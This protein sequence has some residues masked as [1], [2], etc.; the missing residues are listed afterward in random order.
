MINDGDDNI[1]ENKGL[2]EMDDVDYYFN[3]INEESD[4]SQEEKNNFNEK[5]YIISKIYSEVEHQATLHV[6]GFRSD[7]YNTSSFF[8]SSDHPYRGVNIGYK[9]NNNNNNSDGVI[10]VDDMDD[11]VDFMSDTD[12][13]GK[14][15]IGWGQV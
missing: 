8:R 1:D 10:V 13:I 4:S 15:S 11:C 7:M 9:N 12:I 14:N 3:E 2:G 5:K 6:L